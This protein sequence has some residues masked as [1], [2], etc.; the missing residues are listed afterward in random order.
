MKLHYR[1]KRKNR[2][3]NKNKY[4]DRWEN[5]YN[6]SDCVATKDEINAIA[7]SVF[8]GVKVSSKDF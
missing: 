1:N 3:K 8:G 5:L 4:R 7:V 2:H 6:V